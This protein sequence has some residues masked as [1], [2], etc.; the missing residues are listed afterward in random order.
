MKT[1]E[2]V[3]WQPILTRADFLESRR[4]ATVFEDIA[5]VL[6][7][8]PKTDCKNQMPSLF[9]SP[10]HQDKQGS[11]PL[12][13]AAVQGRLK[14][15]QLLARCGAD[16]FETMSDGTTCVDATVVRDVQTREFLD[17]QRT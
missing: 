6:Q 17:R 11:T 16:V 10:P 3:S 12:F 5:E 8:I 9:A 14:M 15:A 1:L 4:R 7:N 13:S 2:T